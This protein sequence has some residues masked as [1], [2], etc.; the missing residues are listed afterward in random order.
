MKKDETLES[1]L[2]LIDNPKVAMVLKPDEID[3]LR[4]YARDR[5]AYNER[6]FD[7][8]EQKIVL[9]ILDKLFS[10]YIVLHERVS[11]KLWHYRDK[12]SQEKNEVDKQMKYLQTLGENIIDA[13][14]NRSTS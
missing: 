13:K 11:N 8:K 14:S 7:K 3:F 10:S 6:V 2:N 5:H 9:N 1:I 12:V 4:M